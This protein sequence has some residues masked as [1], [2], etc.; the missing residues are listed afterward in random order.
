MTAL[1]A[2]EPS[3]PLKLLAPL[4]PCLSV[5]TALWVSQAVALCIDER[6]L[7]ACT[8]PAA[9]VAGAINFLRAFLATTQEKAQ[10]KATQTSAPTPNPNP[11]PSPQGTP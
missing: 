11:N 8:D 10:E 3:Q 5:G 2:P 7:A 1:P 4:Q 6:R 9:E